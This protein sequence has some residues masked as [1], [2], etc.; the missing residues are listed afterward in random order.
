MKTTLLKIALLLLPAFAVAQGMQKDSLPSFKGL[1]VD[2]LC[3][4][5]VYPSDQAR[6]EFGDDNI[7]PTDLDQFKIKDEQ[8]EIRVKIP[9][10]GNQVIKVYMPVLE[11]IE[12][13]NV[14]SVD[15]KEEFSGDKL[16]MSL[17]GASTLKGKI[18]Y[19]QLNV[20]VYDAA[21]VTLSGAADSVSAMVYGAGNLNMENVKVREMMMDISDAAAA[22]VNVEQDVYVQS[23][24]AYSLK[25]KGDAIIH[26][27]NE[28]QAGI[29]PEPGNTKRKRNPM[30]NLD[31]GAWNDLIWMGVDLG[32]N[33]FLDKGGSFQPTGPYEFMELDYG[34]SANV[35][36]NILEFKIN[37]NKKKTIN[38]VPGL[39]FEWNHYSFFNKIILKERGELNDPTLETS[40]VGVSDP[41]K[42]I[43]RSRLVAKYI[44]IPLFLNF[45][46]AKNGLKKKQ[47]NFSLGVMA[48]FLI[49]QN[50]RIT[51]QD[52]DQRVREKY[53]RKYDLGDVN[54]VVMA[55]IRY[56]FL[57]FYVSYTAT[58]LFR[59]P[60]SPFLKG[61]S[62]GFSFSI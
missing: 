13:S 61:W 25:I 44:N 9:K 31:F 50:H 3:S 28:P 19:K 56:W 27:L 29:E 60:D 8:L 32:F 16:Q 38:L 54:A 6:Y 1:I 58:D 53:Y 48:N 34:R 37:L 26:R 18:N 55:R 45:A 5:E 49:G 10:K 12:I 35:R 40:L 22:S 47:F 2:C 20:K 51:Y 14:G 62:A 21:N 33:G 42:D 43:V 52:G 17:N 36:L 11:K 59:G 46:T 23:S 7:D 41:D 30:K 39:G 15:L 4:V 57:N 24:G